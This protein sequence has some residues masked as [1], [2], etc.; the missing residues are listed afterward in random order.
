MV[1][2][3]FYLVFVGAVIG[4]FETNYTAIESD[5]FV[6]LMFGLISGGVQK[7]VDIQLTIN[8]GSAQGIC[9]LL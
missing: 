2:V 8:S 4:F 7:P 9:K 5:G 6:T 3:P 1:N